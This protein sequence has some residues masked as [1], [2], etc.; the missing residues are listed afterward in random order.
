MYIGDT[1]DHMG[2][3]GFGRLYFLGLHLRGEVKDKAIVS[4]EKTLGF[5][6]NLLLVHTSYFSLFSV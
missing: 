4:R 6:R 5:L 3:H 2:R 1:I